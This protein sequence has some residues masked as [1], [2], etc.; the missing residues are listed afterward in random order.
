[1]SLPESENAHC[2]RAIVKRRGL[3]RSAAREAVRTLVE[4]EDLDTGVTA[5]EATARRVM[6]GNVRHPDNGG[7]DGGL[8]RT[9]L[10]TV[11]PTV[12]AATRQ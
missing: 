11:P 3:V 2:P 4:A 10:S 5:G 12:P 9:R 1:M 7:G 8:I 6:A